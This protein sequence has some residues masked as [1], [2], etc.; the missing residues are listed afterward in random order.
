M[1]IW[2]ITFPTEGPFNFLIIDNINIR[3]TSKILFDFWLKT[4]MDV[5]TNLIFVTLQSYRNLTS[6]LNFASIQCQ[7]IFRSILVVGQLF[8][9]DRLGW[10]LIVN[11]EQSP[12][13]APLH[14][15]CL[16]VCFLTWFWN[17]RGTVVIKYYIKLI[18]TQL[19]K[20]I[21]ILW[22][23][24]ICKWSRFELEHGQEW[25]KWGHPAF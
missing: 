2:W 24:L 6:Q 7:I 20:L 14:G 22:S 17:T 3:K 12:M 23:L 15:F 25:G 4:V 8:K 5:C 19:F 11:Q 16:F 21:S 13:S 10:I 18:R 1:K 9:W